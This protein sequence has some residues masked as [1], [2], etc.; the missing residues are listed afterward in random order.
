VATIANITPGT[1][2]ITNPRIVLDALMRPQLVVNV[3]ASSGTLS[4]VAY[5]DTPP[6]SVGSSNSTMPFLFPNVAEGTTS[7]TV[8]AAGPVNG[9]NYSF[10]GTVFENSKTSAGAVMSN[11][12]LVIASMPA[13]ST[14]TQ[15]LSGIFKVFIKGGSGQ[16]SDWTYAVSCSQ[17]DQWRSSITVLNAYEYQ[18]TLPVQTAPACSMP[19]AFRSLL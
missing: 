10:N 8:A 1:A 7:T 16:Q 6:Y 17:Y 2:V 5:S 3:S 4:V 14:T 19:T 13:A 9:S 15:Q 12:Q 18:S 11:G